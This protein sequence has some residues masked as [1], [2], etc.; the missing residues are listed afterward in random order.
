M[1]ACYKVNTRFLL[2][3]SGDIERNPGPENTE[4]GQDLPKDVNILKPDGTCNRCTKNAQAENLRCAICENRFHVIECTAPKMCTSTFL[5]TTYPQLANLYPCITFMC[6]FCRENKKMKDENVMMD[7]FN[8]MEADI[9]DIKQLLRK[10]KDTPQPTGH[11]P[12]WA[13]K[14]ANKPAAIVIKQG[15]SEER[16]DRPVTADNLEEIKNIAIHK[17][18]E[19]LSTY[20]N[21]Q[22][23]HVIICQNERSK[24]A[25][26]PH[27]VETFPSKTL[28]TPPPR[29]PT[30]TIKDIRGNYDATQ[31]YDTIK[32]QNERIEISPDNFNI[33]FTKQVHDSPGTHYAVVRVSDKVRD[34]LKANRDTLFIGL[35]SCKI[36]DRFFAR[37]CNKCQAIGHYHGQCENDTSVCAKCS[38]N[39]DTRSCHTTNYK[40]YNCLLDNR[41][42]TKHPAYSPKCPV[43]LAA[44]AKVKEK[45]SYYQKN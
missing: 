2:I 12:T 42:D 11:T 29:C 8:K 27:L 28:V 7:R 44:Q 24:E 13:E 30:I 26:M 14:V 6:D 1:V 21:K 38:L 25:L 20:K 15:P 37:R 17:S 40:C 16:D 4:Q 5:K 31:L 36:R 35:N 3:L 33:I 32:R 39:H 18:A 10:D 9:R 45:I 34:Q 41:T 43:Y 22:G 19:V 23:N